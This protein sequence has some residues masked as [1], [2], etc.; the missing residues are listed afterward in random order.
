MMT[1]RSEEILDDRLIL[2]DRAQLE[3]DHCSSHPDN[4]TPRSAAADAQQGFPVSHRPRSQQA[5]ERPR[6]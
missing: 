6:W 5:T 4:V 3:A 2:I 1:V